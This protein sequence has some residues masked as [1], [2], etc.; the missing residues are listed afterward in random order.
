[1]ADNKPNKKTAGPIRRMKGT[2][3]FEHHL[4]KLGQATMLSNA[5]Y[6]QFQP[7]LIEMEHAHIFHSVNDKNGAENIYCSPTGGHFHQVTTEWA[8]D[9]DGNM[10]LIKAE[11]GV[12][13]EKVKKKMRSG[14]VETRIEVVKFEVDDKD[15]PL[16]DKHIHEVIYIDTEEINPIT[17]QRQVEEDRQK[18]MHQPTLWKHDSSRYLLTGEV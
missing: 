11:C 6:K 12:A 4:F 1:M 10:V 5:S 3:T 16:F 13:I 7:K 15:H 9:A 2:T 18:I 17:R 14:M 8:S